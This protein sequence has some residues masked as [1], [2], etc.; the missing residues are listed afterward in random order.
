[1]RVDAGIPAIG[2]SIV[3]GISAGGQ[4]TAGPSWPRESM[5]FTIRIANSEEQIEKA[6][7]IRH[8]AYAR[9]V[10]A[11]ADRLRE[12]ED[13][14]FDKGSVV[15]LA[16]SKLDGS[17]LG[18]MR[19]QTNR[20]GRLSLEQ[21]VELPDWLQGRS[22]AE[23]TRL[24][25]SLGRQGRVVKV[26]LFKAFLLYC[27]DSEIDWMVITARSPLDS[28]YDAL[29]FRDVFPG[30]GFISMGHVGNIPH[31]VMALAPRLVETMWREARHG[32][33]ECFFQVEHP[34]IKVR[35]KHAISANGRWLAPSIERAEL[36]V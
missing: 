24:G 10:P 5:P 30:G 25:I 27:L 19:I 2:G 1:M 32:L 33:Y 14:D 21:S 12:A 26:M 36:R 16:E 17:P 18:T 29:L 13:Y 6:V 4:I 9:H 28:Q 34:D 3:A 31:R 23:A 35:G 7:R 8:A 20:Y 15:L 11:F 22:L